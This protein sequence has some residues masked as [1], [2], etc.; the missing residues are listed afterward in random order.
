MST[1]PY[2]EDLREKV[3][4][5]IKAGN[6]QRGASK[7]FSINKM[8]VN[9]WYL[10]YKN[11]G[12]CRAKVRLGAKPS[13]ETEDFVQ[14][15]KIIRMQERRILLVNLALALVGRDIG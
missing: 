5:F 8:T 3:I 12:H 14:Y 9:R 2:S 15:V 11:E 10:R 7:V 4:R 1:S 6:S 13:I